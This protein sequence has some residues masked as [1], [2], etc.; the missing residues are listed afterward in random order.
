MVLILRAFLVTPDPFLDFHA[1]EGEEAREGEE[2]GEGG[3]GEEEES[4]HCG[5]AWIVGSSCCT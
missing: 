5:R 3:G 1:A 2:G 4:F